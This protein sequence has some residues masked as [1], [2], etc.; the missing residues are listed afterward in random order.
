MKKNS[1]DLCKNLK[2]KIA[3]FYYFITLEP[4]IVFKKSEA[5]FQKLVLFEDQLEQKHL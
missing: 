1:F 2:K 3:V 5:N 4:K